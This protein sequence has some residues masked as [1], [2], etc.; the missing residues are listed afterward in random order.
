MIEISVKP[1]MDKSIDI[2]QES[3]DKITYSYSAFWTS[4]DK[5]F[6]NRMSKYEEMNFFSEEIEIQWFSIVNSLIL[7]VVLTS[8][9]AFIITRI[10]KRD[11]QAY[12]DDDDEGMQSLL[13]SISFILSLCVYR[14][15][16]N[17][18]EVTTRKCF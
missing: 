3:V 16:R 15:G 2:N 7:V 17:W 12:A 18:M 1:D 4:T 5:K 9:L 13:R 10:L 14:Q 11:Y 8:F 6:E